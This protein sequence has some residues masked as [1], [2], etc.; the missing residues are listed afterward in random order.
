MGKPATLGGRI[1]S[2]KLF[3]NAGGM[4]CLILWNCLGVVAL[5]EIAHQQPESSVMSLSLQLVHSGLCIILLSLLLFS[6]II[7]LL[8]VTIITVITTVN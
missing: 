7:I 1:V 3:A 8:L 6:K 5:S 2:T 4:S